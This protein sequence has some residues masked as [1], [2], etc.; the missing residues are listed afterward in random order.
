ME[1]IKEQVFEALEKGEL[2]DFIA[3]NYYLMSKEELKDILLEVLWYLYFLSITEESYKEN[4]QFI[5]GALSD[6]WG[7]GIEE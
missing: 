1:N 2:Y 3:N 7:C 4:Q 5:A 6:R